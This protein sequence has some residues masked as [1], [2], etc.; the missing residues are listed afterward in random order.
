MVM[1]IV[2]AK[3][4]LLVGIYTCACKYILYEY[5][6]TV[7]VATAIL[8]TLFLAS[9]ATMLRVHT[10]VEAESGLEK[11]TPLRTF[12]NT[13]ASRQSVRVVERSFAMRLQS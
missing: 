1:P 6:F 10:P 11:V 3:V 8:L 2:T 5:H 13:M 7:T 12:R 9:A 4:P